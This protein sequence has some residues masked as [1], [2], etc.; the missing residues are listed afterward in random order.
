MPNLNHLTYT[1]T[2]TLKTHEYNINI[3]QITTKNRATI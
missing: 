1:N 2:F 3:N